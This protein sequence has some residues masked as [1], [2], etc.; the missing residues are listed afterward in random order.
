MHVSSQ[1]AVH[2]LAQQS[3]S[4]CCIE[5]IEVE[6]K[7]KVL[8]MRLVT[9]LDQLGHHC[10]GEGEGEEREREGRGMSAHLQF[11]VA[12]RLSGSNMDAPM[13]RNRVLSLKLECVARMAASAAVSDCH[14]PAV[15]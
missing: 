1:T 15:T 5:P 14:R 10:R 6:P 9:T 3:G 12:Y 8:E 4:H 2:C 13:K 7:G 11:A